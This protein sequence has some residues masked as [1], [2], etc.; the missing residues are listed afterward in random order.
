MD[1]RELPG[2][3]LD[4]AADLVTASSAP[5]SAS[6]SADLATLGRELGVDRVYVFENVRDP[7]G[8]LWMNLTAE[9]L[10]DGTRG[11]FDDPGTRLHPYSPDF[12]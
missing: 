1:P 11:L 2:P 12:T 10:R 3:S 4:A 9:W 8:R 6:L 7:D 5:P